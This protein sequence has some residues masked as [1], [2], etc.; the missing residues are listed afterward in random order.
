MILLAAFTAAA[1]R[2][3]LAAPASTPGLALDLSI[4]QPKQGD[5][6][7]ATLRSATPL[8]SATLSD[9]KREIVMEDAG[10][11]RVFRALVGIDF[12]SPRTACLVAT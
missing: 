10:D 1:V 4:P 2:I 7:V 9:G 8:A 5:I 6:V 11:G 12:E 3:L